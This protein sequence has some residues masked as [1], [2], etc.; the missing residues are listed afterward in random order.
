MA[1]YA[2]HTAAEF[3]HDAAGFCQSG[4]GPGRKPLALCEATV[5]EIFAER[6]ALDKQSRDPSLSRRLAERYNVTAKAI[7]NIWNMR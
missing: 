3:P 7:R 2:P 4:P 1:G 6:P 5:L